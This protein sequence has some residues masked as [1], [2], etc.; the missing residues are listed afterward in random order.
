MRSNIA[1]KVTLTGLANACVTP[2]R[3]LLKQF[4]KLVR[5]SPL[6]AP[7]GSCN[8]NRFAQWRRRP[9]C[10]R[11]VA[12]ASECHGTWPGVAREIALGHQMLQPTPS[13]QV[14]PT[15]RR[16]SRNGTFRHPGQG[17]GR[18]VSKDVLYPIARRTVSIPV[19]A[20]WNPMQKSRK[21]M[22]RPNTRLPFSPRNLMIP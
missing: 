7:G 22:S 21:A 6:W 20:T 4:Q 19:N 13:L 9:V 18:L 8:P 5:L 2:G 12:T 16:R 3:T 17:H 11:M 14:C 10:W 1:E 15:A